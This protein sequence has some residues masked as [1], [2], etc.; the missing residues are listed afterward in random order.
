MIEPIHLSEMI[1]R[2]ELTIPENPGHA[3]D[4][5]KGEVKKAWQQE[6]GTLVQSMRNNIFIESMR[7]SEVDVIQGSED[8]WNQ[9]K[10]EID[11]KVNKLGLDPTQWNE[12]L[13]VISNYIQ[14]R[15]RDQN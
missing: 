1:R 10:Q 2:V 3:E 6:I 7:P 14:N 13:S 9:F 5:K 15:N 8:E 4:Y 12:G 11:K